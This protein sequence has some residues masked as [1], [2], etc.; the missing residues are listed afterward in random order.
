MS[1]SP[2]RVST[3]VW[4]FAYGSNM[5][6]QKFTGS[7][8]IKPLKRARVRLPGWMMTMSI[9]GVPYSEPAFSAVQER[10]GQAPDVIGVAYL[11]TAAQYDHV[12]ASEGGGIAYSDKLINA[13]PL[14]VQDEL[15][16]GPQPV[17][18]TLCAAM[19][20]RPPARPSDRYMVS[21]ML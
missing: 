1:F 2:V 15:Q 11:L 19:E 21:T 18:H 10:E 6:S 8:G 3:D 12:I 4:Y 16:T 13:E 9:P 7:R 17:V 5:S 14:T 20:R